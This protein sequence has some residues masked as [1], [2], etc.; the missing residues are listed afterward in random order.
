LPAIR[1]PG[2]GFPQ[3]GGAGCKPNAEEHAFPV[4][5]LAVAVCRGVVPGIEKT[6]LAVGTTVVFGLTIARLLA[7]IVKVVCPS[8][9][10]GD[11]N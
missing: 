5:K 6:Q 4:L 10:A 7:V 3:P 9:G 11:V 2:Y 8:D 1:R